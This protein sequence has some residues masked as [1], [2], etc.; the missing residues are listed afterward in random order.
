MIYLNRIQLNVLQIIII[1]L[2]FKRFHL[3]SRADLNFISI[4]IAL[5]D[6]LKQ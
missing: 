2:T 1:S 6:K 4:K 5:Y 3:Q